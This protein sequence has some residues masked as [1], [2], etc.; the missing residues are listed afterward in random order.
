[1]KRYFLGGV[2]YLIKSFFNKIG[3][4]S[5][6]FAKVFKNQYNNKSIFSPLEKT[7]PEKKKAAKLYRGFGLSQEYFKKEKKS[8]FLGGAGNRAHLQKKKKPK[9]PR[10]RKKKEKTLFPKEYR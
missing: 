3:G 2:F 5:P 6:F 8:F 1:M 7:I 4:G 10:A 9:T